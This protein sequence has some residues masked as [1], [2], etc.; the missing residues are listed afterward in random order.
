MCGSPRTPGPLL[1]ALQHHHAFVFCV[2]GRKPVL[3]IACVT[4]AVCSLLFG[5]GTS[6]AMALAVRFALGLGNGLVGTAKTCV[7]D[8]LSKEEQ[9]RGMAYLIGESTHTHARTHESTL[10]QAHART[11]A[12]AHTHT[13]TYIHV[14]MLT[15][16]LGHAG[17]FTIGSVIGPALGGLLARPAAQYPDLF[18]HGNSTHVSA[19]VFGCVF[20]G[21]FEGVF[22]GCVCVCVCACWVV[23]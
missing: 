5:F 3:V 16:S 6:C 21:W 20:C 22:C 2:R 7:A 17:A 18:L 9:A 13:H 15:P 23:G 12:H 11:H 19:W 1:V 8:F 10:T 4:I 14:N